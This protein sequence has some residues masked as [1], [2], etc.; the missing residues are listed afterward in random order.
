MGWVDTY[1]DNTY[2]TPSYGAATWDGSK[3]I[4]SGGPP[5]EVFIRLGTWTSGYRPTKIKLTI[6]GGSPSYLS[7]RD[8]TGG[9]AVLGEDSS[10]YS[11]K[12]LDLDFSSGE[13]IGRLYIGWDYFNITA[14]SFYEDGGSPPVTNQ[15]QMWIIP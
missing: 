14:I 5:E 6:T 12:E 2:W 4:I 3:W 7:V 13:D 9:T 11:D 10:Y 8:Y 15:P 1:F